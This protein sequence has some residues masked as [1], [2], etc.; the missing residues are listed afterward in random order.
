M[1]GVR[2]EYSVNSEQVANRH[3]HVAPA[4]PSESDDSRE[5]SSALEQGAGRTRHF[6]VVETSPEH[7]I[8]VVKRI[9]VD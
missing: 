7:G 4:M 3:L 9:D 6:L 2:H 8:D 1:L 5:A